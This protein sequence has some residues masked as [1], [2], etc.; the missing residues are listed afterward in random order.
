MKYPGVYDSRTQVS[1]ILVL[2]SFLF[3]VERPALAVRLDLCF[4]SVIYLFFFI[5]EHLPNRWTYLNKS[6]HGDG[7]WLGIEYRYG[8]F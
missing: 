7:N 1:K 2:I 6:L 8:G 4:R 5:R 3:L